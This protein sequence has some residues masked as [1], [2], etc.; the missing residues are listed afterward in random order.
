MATVQWSIEAQ[1]A[2]REQVLIDMFR[3]E[4]D[5]DDWVIKEFADLLERNYPGIF[6]RQ[7][8]IAKCKQKI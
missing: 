8:F 2:R 3:K 5:V 7:E 4:D 6:K 1:L